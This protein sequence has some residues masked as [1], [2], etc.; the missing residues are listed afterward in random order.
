MRGTKV[1]LISEVVEKASLGKRE[2]VPFQPER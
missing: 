2:D 1:E